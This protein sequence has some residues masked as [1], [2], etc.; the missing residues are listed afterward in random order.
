VEEK[1]GLKL[2][3]AQADI[4]PREKVFVAGQFHARISEKVLNPLTATAWVLESGGE[5]AVFVSCDLV[6]ISPLLLGSVREKLKD[7]CDGLDPFKVVLNATHTHTAPDVHVP[8]GD[9]GNA[10]YAGVIDFGEP[11]MTVEDYAA[12]A[13]EQ[14]ASAVIQAWKERAPGG[15]AFG[16]GFA[17]VGRNRRWVTANGNSIMYSLYEGNA[18]QFRHIEGYEDHSLN[19]IAAYNRDGELTGLVVNVPSPS[20]EGE[21][22]F[23]L[24]ADFWHETRRELRRRFGE[25]LFVLPQCSAAGEQT[26]HLMF[27]AKAYHRMLELKKRTV[28]EDIAQRIS[29]EAEEIVAAI[30]PTIDHDPVLLHQAEI[31]ELATSRLSEEDVRQAEAEAEELQAVYEAEMRKLEENP[32]LREQPRWYVPVTAAYNKMK[33]LQEVAKRYKR[34]KT[35]STMPAEVHVVRLGDVAIATCPFE[36]YLDF[37]IQIKVRSPAV[38]TFLVQLAGKGTYVPSPRSVQGGGYGSIPANNPVGPEGGQQ[39]ADYIVKTMRFLWGREVK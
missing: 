35:E 18:D 24:S 26:T 16:Q 25:N 2:G 27:E 22:A 38:Q 28:F 15:I 5:H 20:Q 34:Q 9:F 12:F 8:S 17:V 23:L 6:S 19:V 21:N 39:L 4:T 32:Q 13:A 14:I 7:R 1:A 33:W 31:V 11:V 3:W 30:R 10:A 29:N 37:G 36:Y